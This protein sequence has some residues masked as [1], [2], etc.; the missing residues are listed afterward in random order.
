M[1]MKDCVCTNHRSFAEPPG[2]MLSPPAWM[3]VAVGYAGSP[4]VHQ[5]LSCLEYN[6]PRSLQAGWNAH[7]WRCLQPWL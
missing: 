5:C 3:R 6:F 2:K 1:Q 7:D 4:R